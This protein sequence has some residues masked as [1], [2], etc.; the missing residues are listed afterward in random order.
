MN[1]LYVELERRRGDRGPATE[2][3]LDWQVARVDPHMIRK[4]ILTAGRKVTF[5][6]FQM[7]EFGGT[8]RHDLVPVLALV[9]I[10]FT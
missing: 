8:G 3:A 9:L 10:A 4:A 5:F 1:L 2:S 7:F 6:T